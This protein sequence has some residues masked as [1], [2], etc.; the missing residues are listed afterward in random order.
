MSSSKFFDTHEAIAQALHH[1]DEDAAALFGGSSVGGGD[2]LS[3][4]ARKAEEASAYTLFNYLAV[5]RIAMKGSQQF[6]I[7]GTPSTMKAGE[8]R[9]VPARVLKLSIKEK[10]EL[11]RRHGGGII[12]SAH[13]EVESLPDDHPLVLLLR[14]VNPTDWWQSFMFELLLFFELTGETFI[15]MVPSTTRSENAPGGIPIQLWV[16]PTQW[17]EIKYEKSGRIKSYR[18]TPNNDSRKRKDIDPD[19]IIHIMMKNPLDKNRGYSPSTAGGP[20]IESNISIERSRVHTFENSITPSVWLKIAK[21][22]G[23]NPKDDAILDRIKSRWIQ[24]ASG[25][26]KFREPVIIPPGIE[27]DATGNFNPKEMD[28]GTSSNEVRDNILALRGVNKFVAGF[29]EGMNRAQVETALV[30]MCEF[31]MNPTLDM[32][33]GALQEKLVPKFDNRIRLWFPDCSPE[34][35]EQRLAEL[36]FLEKFGLWPNEARSEYGFEP[37]DEDEY[38]MGYIPGGMVPLGMNPSAEL[39]SEEEEES[40]EKIAL[41]IYER[42]VIQSKNGNGEPHPTEILW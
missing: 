12:Q 7:I 42:Q 19:E 2:F 37:V 4:T 20:W 10:R 28:Y 33:G 38:N 16:I 18:V 24:R 23:I 39:P 25:I 13:Q 14:N 30:H 9:L 15:W 5:T 17:V 3:G 21:D 26:Q 31:T 41:D 27:V 22:S 32:V 34:N 29:T 6:P 8:Q 40:A 1:P 11:I 35:R 36:K